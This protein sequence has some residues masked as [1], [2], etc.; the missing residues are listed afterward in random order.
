MVIY[1]IED[2]FSSFDLRGLDRLDGYEIA[3]ENR[4]LHAHAMSTESNA[5]PD[6]Q[7]IRTQ[8]DKYPV[9]INGLT[10]ETQKRSAPVRTFLLL[11]SVIRILHHSFIPLI[12]PITLLSGTNRSS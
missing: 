1:A 6:L 9:L 4:G 7:Q 3:V 12:N 10:A 5:L 2:N 8:I 11:R